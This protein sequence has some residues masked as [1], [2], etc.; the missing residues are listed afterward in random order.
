MLGMCGYTVREAFL[1]SSNKNEVKYKSVQKKKKSLQT[2]R[3]LGAQ[4]LESEH[5]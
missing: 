1:S 4:A 2:D 3:P 5:N